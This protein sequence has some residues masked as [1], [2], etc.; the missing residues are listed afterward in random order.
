MCDIFDKNKEYSFEEIAKI[1]IKNKLTT[2]DCLKDENIISLESFDGNELGGEN[3]FEFGRITDNV[4]NLRWSEP[5]L[6]KKGWK[7]IRI[8]EHEI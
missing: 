4:F 3:V 1:A 8:W 2:I 7:V 6:R 5:N